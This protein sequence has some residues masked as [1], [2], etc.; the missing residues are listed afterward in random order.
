MIENKARRNSFEEETHKIIDQSS[1]KICY[2]QV[3]ASEDRFPRNTETKR[4]INPGNHGEGPKSRKRKETNPPRDY[5][6]QRDDPKSFARTVN[7]VEKA[8]GGFSI[9]ES[10]DP[11]DLALTLLARAGDVHLNPGPRVKCPVCT[12]GIYDKT[13]E[14]VWRGRGGYVHLK[15]T[16]LTNSRQWDKGFECNKCSWCALALGTANGIRILGSYADRKIDL[17][18]RLQRMRRAAF[19]VKKRIK[20]TRL[21]KRQQGI[22]AQT[23]VESTALFDAAVRPWYKSE[24]NKLQR[25]IDRLYRFIWATD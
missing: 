4:Q 19:V 15:C 1:P 10:N 24:I 21:T 8:L 9:T 17:T 20:K 6:P 13:Q 2:L 11:A 12:K 16:N 23:C 22:V 18:M 25:E 7:D 3:V 5:V 14:S